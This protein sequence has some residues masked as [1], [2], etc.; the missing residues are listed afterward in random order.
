MFKWHKFVDYGNLI[1]FC[2][3]ANDADLGIFG[4]ITYQLIG[5][6]AGTL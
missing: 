1:A 6:G 5:F 3:Q 4:Q 2:L